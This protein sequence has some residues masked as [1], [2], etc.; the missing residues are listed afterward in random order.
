M[1]GHIHYYMRSK[2]MNNGK[3]VNS[4]ENGTVYVVSTGTNGNHNDIGEE[5]YAEKRF[6]DGQFY[7]HMDIDR[8]ILKYTT[9]NQEGNIVDEFSIVK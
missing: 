1:G 3:V 5:S 6:K 4:F 8:N 7:Q 9:Y 2:P